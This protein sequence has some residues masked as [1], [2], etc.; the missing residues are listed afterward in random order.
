MRIV[1]LGMALFIL[2]ECPG[3]CQEEP[4]Q[5]AIRELRPLGDQLQAAFDKNDLGVAT[6]ERRA[7]L[8]E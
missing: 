5:S 6:L 8:T 3:H 2:F 4:A 1:T 7:N